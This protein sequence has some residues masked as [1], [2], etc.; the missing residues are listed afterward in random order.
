MG[1]DKH[2]TASII[3][4][5][6]IVGFI[7][8]A[9]AIAKE[10]EPQAGISLPRRIHIHGGITETGSRIPPAKK[11]T[12]CGETGRPL[13]HTVVASTGK[14]ASCRRTFNVAILLT[15]NVTNTLNE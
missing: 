8:I 11:M 13:R 9:I 1:F 15:V 10:L 3:I 12:S 14:R 6:I 7:A 2:D 5:I 4:I